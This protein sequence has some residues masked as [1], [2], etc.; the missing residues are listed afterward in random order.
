MQL[1]TYPLIRPLEA[2]PH[3]FCLKA[4]IYG[5]SHR[6]LRIL[7]AFYN[8]AVQARLGADPI[9]SRATAAEN[10]RNLGCSQV[11]HDAVVNHTLV[12]TYSHPVA[13]PNVLSLFWLSL[14]LFNCKAFH[15]VR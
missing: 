2:L 8:D 12:G 11:F 10:L 15:H 1:R 5:A 6:Y 9:A 13:A 7:P 4:L 14:L 3:P